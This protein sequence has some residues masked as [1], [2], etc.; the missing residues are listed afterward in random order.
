[1]I[2]ESIE[3]SGI[4]H[5]APFY[6]IWT[7]SYR[8]PVGPFQSCIHCQTEPATDMVTKADVTLGCLFSMLTGLLQMDFGKALRCGEVGAKLSQQALEGSAFA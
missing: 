4:S 8:C 5:I 1:M 2:S 6:P 3:P 7:A